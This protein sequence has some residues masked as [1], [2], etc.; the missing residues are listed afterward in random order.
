MRTNGYSLSVSPNR[1]VLEVSAS[2]TNTPLSN[3]PEAE[4]NSLS[5]SPNRRVTEVSASSTNT[6]L[7]NVPEAE[8]IHENDLG[9]KI[10]NMCKHHAE[11]IVDKTATTKAKDFN[12]S[13]P[14]DVQLQTAHNGTLDH[15]KQIVSS[16]IKSIIFCG[17]HDMSLRG[18]HNDEGILLDMLK[19]RIEAGDESC[20]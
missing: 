1:R 6:P 15:N 3:V 12:E 13:V 14:V 7:S 4:A 20:H 9:R 10:H 5:V 17:T 2:S 11:S 18:K 8:D 16:I 19:L